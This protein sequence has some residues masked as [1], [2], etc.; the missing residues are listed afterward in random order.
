MLTSSLVSGSQT[1]S[2]VST[3]VAIPENTPFKI[4]FQY[5]MTPLPSFRWWC[6]GEIKKNFT[7]AEILAGQGGTTFQVMVPGMLKK[8]APYFCQVSAF[9]PEGE[10]KSEGI[11]IPIGYIPVPLAAPHNVKVVVGGSLSAKE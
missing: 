4:E 7:N 2:T 6:D 1:T 11:N 8:V 10:M 3:S 5:D 9:T